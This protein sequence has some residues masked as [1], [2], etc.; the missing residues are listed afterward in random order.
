MD[1]EKVIGSQKSGPVKVETYVEQQIDKSKWSSFKDSF[2]PAELATFD[3]TGMTENEILEAQLANAPLSRSLKP[4][5]LQMIAIGGSIGTGL[6]VG[7]GASLATG[8]PASLVIGFAIIGAILYSMMQALGELTV[9]LPVAGTFSTFA[10][11]FIDKS[12]GFAL[13]WVYACE[14]LIVFPLE[15]VAASI[16]IDYWQ[17][18]INPAAWVTIFYVVILGIN[19]F[20]VRGYGEAEFVFSIIKV[21][22]VVGFVI[23]GIVINCGGGPNGG[24]IG[25]KYWHDPGSFAHGSWRSFFTVLINATFSFS[26]SELVGLAAAEAENPRKSLPR[27]IKQVFWRILLFYIVSLIVIG[28]LVP[29]NNP[30]LLGNS[31]VD[32]AA[33][34]FVIAIQNAGIKVLPSIFNVVIMIA[35]LSVGN[36]AVFGS[37]R[38]LAAMAAQGLAPR[39]LAYIDRN[40][41]PLA[42]LAVSFTFGLLCFLSATPNHDEVFSWLMA[43]T[44][45]VLI[46]IW[47][48]VNLCHI[49]F[50]MALKYQG[51][52]TDE[53]AYK[54]PT[55]L[56]GSIVSFIALCC[57]LIIQFWIAV[58]PVGGK[59]N[60]S[61]FF[62]QFLACPI[63][64]VLF[65]SH[66][67]IKRTGILRTKDIDIDTGRREVDID[68][69]RQELEEERQ[70]LRSKP[71]W[72]RAYNT[73]C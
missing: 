2:R 62:Q 68:E 44:G 26:G 38:T 9:A 56:I 33:S 67:L 17:S 6:F 13:G 50:R 70:Y 16:T 14:Y 34:P 3:T 4:R 28:F 8:G 22:A 71:W 45:L 55:G 54:S 40:G 51:R 35:V 30:Q 24:Y 59:P 25:A 48:T 20:G 39:Q 57:I 43:L 60:A 46:F 23:L 42:A 18:S 5:H 7:S 1:E 69:L 31:S 12:W 41:R 37:S 47:A 27:A 61:Y 58:W 53:L 21:V 10:G 66:K 29:Y 63:I 32:I 19:I 64:L 52:S 49:R 73:W 72:Y 65:L 36:A 15:L 11:R